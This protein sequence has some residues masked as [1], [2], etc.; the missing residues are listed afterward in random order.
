MHGNVQKTLKHSHASNKSFSFKESDSVMILSGHSAQALLR[1]IS[2]HRLDTK[3][4]LEEMQTPAVHGG[5]HTAACCTGM[6]H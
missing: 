5:M 2:Y 6:L 4:S 1:G 3:G